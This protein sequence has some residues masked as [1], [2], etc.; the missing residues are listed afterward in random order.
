MK[1][2]DRVFMI[3]QKNLITAAE[4][5]WPRLDR[6]LTWLGKGPWHATRDGNYCTTFGG[7]CVVRVYLVRHRLCTLKR[8]HLT[9]HRDVLVEH[10]PHIWKAWV[11]SAVTSAQAHRLRA[12]PVDTFPRHLHHFVRGKRRK[13]ESAAVQLGPM[14]RCVRAGLHT[15]DIWRNKMRWMMAQTLVAAARRAGQPLEPLLMCAELRMAERGD[16]KARIKEFRAAAARAASGR[17]NRVPCSKRKAA[18]G[19]MWCPLNGDTKACAHER[20]VPVPG[21]QD[22]APH[23]MWATGSPQ[24]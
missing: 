4:I 20:G 11:R 23:E 8:G 2:I 13:V 15:K 1:L 17:F 6:A 3:S 12:D 5:V 19:G 22:P 10:F 24:E 21:V 9:V 16:G 14:P 18:F 7:E